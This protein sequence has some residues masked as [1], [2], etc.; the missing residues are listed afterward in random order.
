MPMLSLTKEGS[1]RDETPS[2]PI[3]IRDQLFESEVNIGV[4]LDA[5]GEASRS[6]SLQMWPPLALWCLQ[7]RMGIPSVPR[8]R[9]WNVT[10]R[11]GNTGT[12]SSWPWN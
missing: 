9:D 8:L 12:I 11:F 4:S 1:E 10:A 7:R 3:L 2:S 5:H 6:H